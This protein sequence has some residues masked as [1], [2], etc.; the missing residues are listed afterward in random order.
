[1][2]IQKQT[3]TGANTEANFLAVTQQTMVVSD[4]DENSSNGGGGGGV[5]QEGG[6]NGDDKSDLVTASLLLGFAAKQF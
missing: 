3:L 6:E 4:D 1:M 2:Q 5:G